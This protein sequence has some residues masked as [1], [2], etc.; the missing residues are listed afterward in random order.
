[1]KC[2][3]IALA[4]AIAMTSSLAFAQAGGGAATGAA[5]PET[6]G[7]AV[8]SG[9]GAVGTVDRGRIVDAPGATTGLAPVAPSGPGREPG[10][11]DESRPGGQGVNDRP[12]GN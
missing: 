10:R 4:T 6:S 8:N 11:R 5:V 12:A 3:T 9:G 2:S 7:T 1:M